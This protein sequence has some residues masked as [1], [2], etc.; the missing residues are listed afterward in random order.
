[1]IR[2]PPRSTRTDT[3]FPY[4]TLF[5]SPVEIAPARVDR[6]VVPCGAPARLTVVRGNE[7]A[8]RIVAHQ[9]EQMREQGGGHRAAHRNADAGAAERRAGR[10]EERRVGREWFSKCRYRWSP[11]HE[12]KKK[13]EHN[14]NITEAMTKP[15]VRI[16]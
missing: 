11:Y 4:T 5:R 3:R 16:E 10:A 13:R 8:L 7:A 6:R 2:R 12:K 9:P 14:T 1:M 15:I